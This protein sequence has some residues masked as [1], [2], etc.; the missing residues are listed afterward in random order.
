VMQWVEAEHQVEDTAATL[1]ADVGRLDN[2]AH[3]KNTLTLPPSESPSKRD[4]RWKKHV[5]A[6]ELRG[7]RYDGDEGPRDPRRADWKRGIV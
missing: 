2:S 4:K 1:N 6:L 5:Q 3:S 7:E